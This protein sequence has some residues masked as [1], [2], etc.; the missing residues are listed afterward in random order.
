[1]AKAFTIPSIFTALDGVT[2]P[3]RAMS[4]A[5]FGF[6]NRSAEE[7][8]KLERRYRMLSR[9]AADVARQSA[10]IG[11]AFLAPLILSAREAI[12][13]EDSMADIAKTTGLSGSAL[14]N[15][16]NTLLDMSLDTRTTIDDLQKIGEIGG[17]LGVPTKDLTAF[18]DAANKFNVALGKDFSGGVEEATSSVG[19]IA[20]LFSDTRSFTIDQALNKIGSSV[21]EL[22]A[23]GSATSANIVDFTKRLGALPDA[24]KPVATD[25]LALGAYFEEMGITSEIAARGFGD[26]ITTAATNLPKFAKQMG[27]SAVA[28][29]DLLNTNPAQFAKD[30]AQSFKGMKGVDVAR[31]LKRLKI[32]DTGT[33]K[34]VGALGSNIER[35]TALQEISNKAF[36]EGTSLIAEYDKKNNT[37]AA[38]LAKAQ[39]NFKALAI[40][41]GTQLLP[42]ITDLVKMVTPVLK[43]LIGWIRRNPILT[44]GILILVG[45]IGV[46]AL[47]VS[48]IAFI[49]KLWADVMLIWVAR[50]KLVTA[51]QWAWNA[52]M[53]AN[54]IG[55]IIIAIV[56][57][58]VLVA[59]IINKWDEW[60]ATISLFLG[61]LGL[62]ISLV[63]SFRRNWDMITS[64]FREGGIIAG[65]KA[66]GITIFDAILMPLQ[67]AASIVSHLTGAAWASELA[68]GLEDY[69][70]NLGVDV[71]SAANPQ[72]EQ[73]NA[74]ATRMES[75][76]KQNTA[77]TIQDQTGRAN[78]ESDNDITPIRLGKTLTFQ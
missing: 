63:M 61:P 3:M 19:T 54:P 76:Q 15:Y 44:K 18:T 42:V 12:R 24:L 26:I 71:T 28:A 70:K 5:V 37:T 72:A 73:N 78:V 65:I 13:F 74:M 31:T 33:I 21:N 59:V 49:I 22:G 43:G 77:I 62:L 8:A 45:V 68:K 16:G 46:F 57:L 55:I 11:A 53:S 17:Q 14:E 20:T 56:A 69:R 36:V 2:K 29:R 58:I 9:S 48:G 32:G 4:K 35:L 6:A 23:V 39:N 60:G 51:A 66:I 34:T 50:A 7:I 27:I 64:S 67:Q 75:V 40:T 52:A 25:T 1:M 41:A 10:I 38:N 30:F 47:A